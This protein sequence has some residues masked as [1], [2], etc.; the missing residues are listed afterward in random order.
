[1][2][3]DTR[4][5]CKDI[6]RMIREDAYL[7]DAEPLLEVGHVHLH[8]KHVT[9]YKGLPPLRDTGAMS[10]NSYK[11]EAIAMRTGCDQLTSLREK[12]RNLSR[13]QPDHDV[14]A[15][16]EWMTSWQGTARATSRRMQGASHPPRPLG[17]VSRA[18][19]SLGG[20]CNCNEERIPPPPLSSIARA[21][22]QMDGSIPT[23]TLSTPPKKKSWPGSAR[24][25][26]VVSTRA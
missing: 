18:R 2:G 15:L 13:S 7:A 26:C 24:G 1:M 10:D 4:K 9:R 8:H 17:L 21:E 12:T 23:L 20:T 5:V 11:Y 25:G 22:Q 14:L 19:A 3:E 16:D 6:W